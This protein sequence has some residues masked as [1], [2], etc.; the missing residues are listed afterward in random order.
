MISAEIVVVFKHKLCG[1]TQTLGE[2]PSAVTLNSE[3]R[4]VGE[5]VPS[6]VWAGGV[7]IT[8]RVIVKNAKNDSNETHGCAVLSITGDS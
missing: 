1:T 4:G 3:H 8:A 5:R 7:D 6:V 2:S